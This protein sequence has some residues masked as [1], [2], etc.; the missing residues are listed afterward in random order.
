MA[1]G[2]G[3]PCVD[4]AHAAPWLFVPHRLHSRWDCD[5]MAW[6][7]GDLGRGSSDAGASH[8]ITQGCSCQRGVPHSSKMRECAF[9][10]QFFFPFSQ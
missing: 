5:P 9:S 1:Q 8:V 10:L 7:P 3:L 6:A 4:H 2:Q